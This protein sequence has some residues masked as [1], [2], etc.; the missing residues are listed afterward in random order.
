MRRKQTVLHT[1][2]AGLLSVCM[3]LSLVGCPEIPGGGGTC[4]LIP[5]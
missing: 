2:A 1:A 5:R 3:A 4:L